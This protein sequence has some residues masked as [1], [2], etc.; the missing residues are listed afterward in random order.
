MGK[1]AENEPKRSVE[2]K[3]EAFFRELNERQLKDMG[4]DLEELRKKAEETQNGET[5]TK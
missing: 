3:F 5:H 2:C 4:I 1:N